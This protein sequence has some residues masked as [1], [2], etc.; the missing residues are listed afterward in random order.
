MLHY[1][2]NLDL[3]SKLG[4]KINWSYNRTRNGVIVELGL[5]VIVELGLQVLVSWGVRPRGENYSP[6]PY[7][8]RS[9]GEKILP[10][11]LGLGLKP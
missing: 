6:C 8:I 2:L 5:Q 10:M 3:L 11:R 9:W 1:G 7:T 4:Y